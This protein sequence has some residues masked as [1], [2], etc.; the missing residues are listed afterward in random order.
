MHESGT[1]EAIASLVLDPLRAD[2]K[3]VRN[4]FEEFEAATDQEEKR[5]IVAL[6]IGV[7]VEHAYVEETVLYPAFEPALDE[8]CFLY[9]ALE[10]HH[11]MDLL[12]SELKKISADD[13]RFDAKFR[14][15][16]ENVKHHIREE[17]EEMFIQVEES[18]LDWGYL[19]EK[20]SDARQQFAA[21][22]ARSGKP[23][24]KKLKS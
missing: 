20:A 5:R 7:L 1:V 22:A 6:A 23:N 4:L 15:L 11:V 9:E 17:E 16:A 19:S 21:K 12:M 14:V 8:E 2:H 10:E 24:G 3:R 13:P 18:D